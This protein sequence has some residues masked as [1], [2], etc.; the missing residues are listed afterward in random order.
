MAAI[1]VRGLTKAYGGK[2]VLSGVDLDVGSGTVFALLGPNGAGKTTTVHILSTLVAPD[3]GTAIVAG[4]DVRRD[5]D[6]V[7][8]AISLT[9]QFAAVD[10]ILTG[11]ENL[12]LMARLGHL[13]RSAVGARVDALLRRFGLHEARHRPV[14]TYS[15]GMRRRLDIAAGL[16]TTPRVLFLDEPTTGLDPH[17]RNE[18]WAL[19]RELL[20][21]G[22]TVFL[23]TQYLQEADELADRVAVI[24]RGRVIAEGTPEEL[25]RRIGSSRV[26]VTLADGSRESHATDGSPRDIASVLGRLAAGDRDVVGVDL[27]HPSL[28]DV[29]LSLTGRAADGTG[30]ASAGTDGEPAKGVRA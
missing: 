22:V 19:V 23:T 4:S 13:P 20:T 6:G 28:D 17:S 8:G 10:E 7:R 3:G 18:V 29:F 11:R 30:D 9:G 1:S 21:E 16:L 24:D 14:R 12:V 2:Q 15:G 26:E 25:K 27:R 5:P